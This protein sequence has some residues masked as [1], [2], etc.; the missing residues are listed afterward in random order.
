MS[1]VNSSTLLYTTFLRTQSNIVNGLKCDSV[2][3]QYSQTPCIKSKSKPKS[4]S[5]KSF[6]MKEK[7]KKYYHSSCSKNSYLKKFKK[8]KYKGCKKISKSVG[9]ERLDLN[10]VCG[11]SHINETTINGMIQRIIGRA[12]QTEIS[13]NVGGGITL[14]IGGQNNSG[15]FNIQ[16]GEKMM[17]LL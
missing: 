8:Q 1:K 9:F 6:I 11:S 14:T 10:K 17:L 15:I 12:N 3:I 7:Q 5:V 2:I 4:K 16:G 13:R